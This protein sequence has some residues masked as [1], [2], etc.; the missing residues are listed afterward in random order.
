MFKKW[1]KTSCQI[2]INFSIMKNVV[3]PN[4]IDFLILRNISLY[5]VKR[6]YIHTQNVSGHLR[7]T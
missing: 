1:R 7:Q 6:F 4:K 3:M 2:E 5:P